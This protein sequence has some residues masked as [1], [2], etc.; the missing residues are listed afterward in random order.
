VR[1][2]CLVALIL[3]G[4]SAAVSLRAL[5]AGQSRVESRLA[6]DAVAVRAML[7]RYCV[8]CHNQRLNTAGLALDALD[9]RRVGD[10]AAPTPIQGASRFIV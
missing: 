9:L 10:H 4:W 8:T 7:D 6:L 2:A 5:P 3:S 1:R